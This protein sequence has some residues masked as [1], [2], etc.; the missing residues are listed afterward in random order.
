MT[1]LPSAGIPFM[2]CLHTTTQTLSSSA[3]KSAVE[4]IMQEERLRRIHMETLETNMDADMLRTVLREERIR[5]SRVAAELAQLKSLAATSQLESEVVEEGRINSLMRR[6]E[7]LQQEKGKIVLELEREEEKLTN[8]LQ[9]KLAKIM[10]EKALLEQQIEREQSNRLA[11]QSWKKNLKPKD[12]KLEKLSEP[13]IGCV[14][15]CLEEYEDEG[16]VD[17]S[18]LPDLAAEAAAKDE[19][20]L[21]KT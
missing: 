6:V 2:P 11:A 16:E 3:A 9:R 12:R 15:S 1:T 13:L 14:N 8:G 19:N 21:F 7:G 10:R 18:I 5:M 17:E 20:Y 4:N